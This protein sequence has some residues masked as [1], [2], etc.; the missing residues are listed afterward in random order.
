MESA[1]LSFVLLMSCQEEHQNLEESDCVASPRAS[2]HLQAMNA[3]LG[4]E[5]P[6][7]IPIHRAMN[8][9]GRGHNMSTCHKHR[10]GAPEYICI[11]K[12]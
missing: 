7:H 3:A 4:I 1:N 12:P 5:V 6:E 9:L 11:Y 8:K 10:W 2:L